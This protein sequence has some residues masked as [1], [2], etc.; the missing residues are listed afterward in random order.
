MKLFEYAILYHPTPEEK[1]K[2]KK[3][4]IVVKPTTVIADSEKSANL[5]AARDIPESY[6]DKL[7]QVEICLRPF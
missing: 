7:E 3:S 1:K 5:L 4:E 6:M 2:G